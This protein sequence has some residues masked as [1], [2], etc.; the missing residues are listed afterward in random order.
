MDRS[1]LQAMP[2]AVNLSARQFRQKDLE[3]RASMRWSAPPAS[4]RR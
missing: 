4:I 2:V 3:A 1:G